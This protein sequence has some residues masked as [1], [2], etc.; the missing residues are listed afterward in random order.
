VFNQPF[1]ARLKHPHPLNFAFPMK[2]GKT[3]FVKFHTHAD[4]S[5]PSIKHLKKP[6]A[7]FSSLFDMLVIDKVKLQGQLLL[8]CLERFRSSFGVEKQNG[9]R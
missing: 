1:Q 2:G 7:G 8:I 6:G 9:A 3:R 5:T 4:G